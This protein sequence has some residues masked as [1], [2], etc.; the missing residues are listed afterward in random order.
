MTIKRSYR[1]LFMGSLGVAL[2]LSNCTVKE[3]DDD[4]CEKGDKDVG[5]DCPGNAEGYQVCGSDGVFGSCICP[6]GTAGSGNTSGSNSGGGSDNE[7]GA[8]NGGSGTTGGTNSTGGT[9]GTS[10]GSDTGGAS[11][12]GA[13]GEAPFSFADCDECL[14]TLCADEWDKCL[15][16]EDELCIEQYA[17]VSACIEDD[18]KNNNVSRDRLRGCGVTLGT[19]ADPNLVGVWAP[20]QMTAETTNLINCLATSSTDLPSNDWADTSGPNFPQA[21]PAPWPADS[22]AKLACTSKKAQ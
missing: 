14:Q 21:G 5:C 2:L 9:G 8:S 4:R 20:D 19:S 12:G 6:D 22:C 13:G 3:D 1:H 17:A 18:R 7:A 16:A 11:D 10:A 15:G